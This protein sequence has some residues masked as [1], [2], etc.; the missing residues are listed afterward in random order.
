MPQ[1]YKNT[2]E[3]RSFRVTV[4]ATILLLTALVMY[5]SL[6]PIPPAE[7]PGLSGYTGRLSITHSAAIINADLPEE[8]A[9]EVL[10]RLS[11]YRFKASDKDPAGLDADLLL[12]FESGEEVRFSTEENR[13]YAQVV[14]AGKTGLY[15]LKFRAY[16]DIKNIV[17]EAFPGGLQPLDRT[18]WWESYLGAAVPALLEQDFKSPREI[19]FEA[20]VNY[21][22]IKMLDDGSAAEFTVPDKNKDVV[23]YD[24]MLIRA[25]AF[26]GDGAGATLKQSVFYDAA[27]NAFVFETQ[28]P[29]HY[30]NYPYPDFSVPGEDNGFYKLK[31]VTRKNTGEIEAVFEDYNRLGFRDDGT[32]TKYHYLTMLPTSDG[33]Y[34]F[35]SKHSELANPEEISVEG[36]FTGHKTLGDFTAD[37]AHDMGFFEGLSLGKNVLFYT[38]KYTKD[39]ATLD[40]YLFGYDYGKLIASHSISSAAGTSFWDI[41]TNENTVII[42]TNET[43][44]MLDE[45]LKEISRTLLPLSS[46]PELDAF[47]YDVTFDL[48]KL[49]YSDPVGIHIYNFRSREVDMLVP[50]PHGPAESEPGAPIQPDV[51]L[52]LL[53]DPVFILGETKLLVS[54]AD[55]MAVKNYSIINLTGNPYLTTPGLVPE[56]GASVYVDDE[57]LILSK[58]P[59]PGESGTTAHTI[60]YFAGGTY[61]KFSTPYDSFAGETGVN[62]NYMFYFTER[63]TVDDGSGDRYYGLVSVDLRT[64][65]ATE[66]SVLIQNAEPEILA[67]SE[68]GR[69]LFSYR[70][71]AGSGFGVTRTTD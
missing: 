47:G 43:I 18:V 11:G 30:G 60:L 15:E 71:P 39:S 13:T 3:F 59:E 19:P 34:R 14:S 68:E 29:E 38:V 69:A 33:G 28:V 40:L 22:R 53:R 2:K 62:G 12:M 50:H 57:K 66:R 55:N 61:R 48:E 44:Y 64:L 25:R 54:H 46:V 65:A 52:E 45:N 41:K 32:L 35:L 63:S 58:Y 31:S 8:K 26:F 56:K 70:S 37:A 21:T 51:V 67:V 7:M 20:V 42:K 5:F 1:N 9:A 36:Y 16:N 27:V 6:R 23:P 17:Y 4:G 49:V 10:K 24:Q